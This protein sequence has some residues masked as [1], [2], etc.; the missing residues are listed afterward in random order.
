MS[1][2]VCTINPPGHDWQNGLTCRWCWDTRT[3]TEAIL[4]G[5][6]SRR[7]GDPT[8]ARQLL[9][10]YRAEVVAE[11]GL[12]PK[13]DVVAWLVK[14]ARE[15]TPIEQLASKVARGAVRPDNLRTLP[16]T[17]FEAGRSYASGTW[18]FRC[19]SISPSPGTGEI[20]ALGWKYSPVCDVHLWHA[21]ALDP[22]DWTHG[23]WADVTEDG[24][25]R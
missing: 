7:G 20:R 24:E 8:S 3:V 15:G 14:K 21:V 2:T 13:A 25:P 1:A 18:Q 9:D 10:A 12:L 11:E 17:F 19:E 6:S 5:L 16:A 4:S 23:G 22:D